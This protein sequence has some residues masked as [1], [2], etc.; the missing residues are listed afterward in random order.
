MNKITFYQ[1]N[2]LLH[3]WMGLVLTIQ[4]LF[5][6]GGGTVMSSLDIDEV[7]GDHLHHQQT[8]ALPVDQY[9]YSL[10]TVLMSYTTVPKQV[11]FISVKGEPVYKLEGDATHYVSALSGQPMPA[12]TSEDIKTIATALF[13]RTAPVAGMVELE[14]L[15]M[16]ARPLKPPMWRVDFADSDNTTFYIHPVS[17]EL[18]RVRSDIW[19]LFDF[20]WMLHIMDYEE[21]EDFNHPLLLAFAVSALLFTFTG[22]VMLYQRLWGMRKRK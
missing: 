6:I 2:R 18:L 20:V 1:W 12:L 13:T 15:P 10:Q 22:M 17:G 7:H 9:Q 8:L 16:E 21:R 3:K 5:W 19:R 14:K 11:K 4:L